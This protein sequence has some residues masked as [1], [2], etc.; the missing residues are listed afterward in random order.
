MNKN[1]IHFVI[2]VCTI[3][4]SLI[5]VSM[6]IVLLYGLFRPEI[7]ND[8]IFELFSPAFSTI[9]GGFIGILSGIKIAQHSDDDIEN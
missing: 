3:T 4:L 5:I 1:L 7:N 8:K 2:I 9:I 6:S